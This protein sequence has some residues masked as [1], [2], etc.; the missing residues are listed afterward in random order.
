MNA[1]QLHAYIRQ[2]VGTACR[3]QKAIRSGSISS[4]HE[5]T[6]TGN[7]DVM[8]RAG[9]LMAYCSR[10]RSSNTYHVSDSAGS[11]GVQSAPQPSDPTDQCAGT[12]TPQHLLPADARV[13][14]GDM[15]DP[16][17]HAGLRSAA[18]LRAW[19]GA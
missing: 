4:L 19:R 10:A 17:C 7:C 13:G 15:S 8:S 6:A 5:Y 11:Q 9:M 14:L 12:S 2:T 16:Q 1:I 3:Q 18:E